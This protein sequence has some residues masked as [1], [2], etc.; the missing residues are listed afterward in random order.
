MT[1]VVVIVVI[2]LIVAL[3]FG[4]WWFV[5]QRRKQE[6]QQ[7]F[8]P[9]YDRTVQQF[10]GNERKAAS[11][12]KDREKRVEA[13]EIRPLSVDA[14]D[15]FTEQWQSTQAQFVDDPSGAVN[16][17]DALIADAMRQIGYPVDEFEQRVDAVSVKYPEVAQ[18]YRTGHEIAQQNESGQ[19]STEDLREAMVRYRSLFERLVGMPQ[20]NQ[21][22][23]A[24]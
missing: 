3:A 22:E 15:R 9:E 6:V 19:A 21:S 18:D 5:Q 8:G 4:A 23:I 10:E 11:E 16:A 1:A 13:V 12:L 14:R 2:V 20:R 24:R 17:A 7:Q